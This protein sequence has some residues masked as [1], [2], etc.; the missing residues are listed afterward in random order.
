MSKSSRIC[1]VFLSSA[2]SQK[3]AA[4]QVAHAL[5]DAELR[6][7]NFQELEKM[8]QDAASL[9]WQ[10]LAESE[11]L[12]GI[13]SPGVQQSAAAAVEIGAA[14]AWHKPVY[15]IQTDPDIPD[16]PSYLEGFHRYPLSRVDDVVTAIRAGR[17]PL[18]DEDMS[19]LS[20]IYARFAVPTDQYLRHPAIVDRL[21]SAFS[22]RRRKNISG[23]RLVQEL[24]RLRKR[25]D[26][27]KV[28]Q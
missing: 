6:V 2:Y 14:M 8:G 9:L 28:R 4:E 17:G 11:A 24:I 7:F 16:L 1:D 15:L 19:A 3:E 13:V 18:S 23:E 25:G 10:A 27:P 12:V 5:R 21:A 22:A 26:L 20:K